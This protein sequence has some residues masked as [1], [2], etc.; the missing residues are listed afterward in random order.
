MILPKIRVAIQ[1]HNFQH[2]LAWMLSSLQQQTIRNE[3]LVDIGYMP[4]NGN[5]TTEE[6]I[7][8]HAGAIGTLWIFPRPY[9]DINRF[10]YRGYVR[11]DQIATTDTEW[12][13]FADTDHV[14]H[15]EYFERLLEYLN[16]GHVDSP[17]FFS[18]GRHSCPVED[19]DALVA[20]LHTETDGYKKIIPN[21]WDR[22]NAGLPEKIKKSNPGAGHSQLIN[23][24]HCPHD[25]YYVKEG[26]SRD[27]AWLGDGLG[28]K[29]NS[30][31]QFRGRVKEKIDHIKLPRWFTDNV[32]H[33][34][35]LRD[36]ENGG[37]T[38]A[39]R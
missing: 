4:N 21:A 25:D 1:C 5:P 38:E 11:N 36:S 18:A 32:Q 20:Q 29:A 27:G 3:I 30:D 39:Q 17:N 2:R 34:N 35:H 24:K 26:K 37:H 12:L 15:P 22:A 13:L 7:R 19:A 33:L 14:Y 28:Q 23:M 31:R 9:T 10:Q 8:L 6:L 16:E